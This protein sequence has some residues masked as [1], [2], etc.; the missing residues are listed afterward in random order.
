[1][2]LGPPPIGRVDEVVDTVTI[3][4]RKRGIIPRFQMTQ[5]A[6]PENLDDILEQKGYKVE[7]SVSIQT[8][9]LDNII[10]QEKTCE[11]IQDPVPTDDWLEAFA[12]G[13]N[14]HDT[15]E[16]RRGLMTRTKNPSSF[17]AAIIDGKVASV[18]QGVVDGSWL[19]LFNVVTIEEYRRRG[20][21]IASTV[22]LAEWA[23]RIGATKAYL[24]VM[25]SNEPAIAL[26]RTLGFKERYH[27]WYR[28]LLLDR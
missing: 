22:A 17:A 18:S 13:S 6:E 11:V 7:L 4:Y 14:H 3:A 25:T 2:P 24:Q 9:L 15:L 16:T 12:I 8:C 10:G 19:G 5:I 27:Y 26:Y 1:M 23:Q 21:A 28:Q 20:A